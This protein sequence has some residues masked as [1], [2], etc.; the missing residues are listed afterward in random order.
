MTIDDSALR[1]ERPATRVQRKNVPTRAMEIRIPHNF[2]KGSRKR[3]M[4]AT[5]SNNEDHADGSHAALQV[6][7]VQGA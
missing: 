6:R 4:C 3:T 1:S 2:E 5:M 7:T